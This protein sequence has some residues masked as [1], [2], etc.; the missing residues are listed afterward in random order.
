MDG[1]AG[2]GKSSVGMLAAKEL[3]YD[4]LSTGEMYRALGY[5]T[6]EKKI[7]VDD[8]QKVTEIAKN[9]KFTFERGTDA[10]LKM[11][12]DGEYLGNKLHSEKVGE[13]A[14]KTSAIPSARAVLT[15]KMREIGRGGG[16]IMEGR[17]IGTVVFPDA[18]IKFYIDATPEE[19]AK[20]RFNQLIQR[21]EKAD[22][23]TILECIRAR[24]L[25]D[26]TRTVAPLKPAED[27]FIIDT[28]SMALEQVVEHILS[29]IKE[30]IKNN[31]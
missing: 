29:V 16:I 11:F 4:F 7:A 27:A 3:G 12:V 20:R 30:K 18:E 22:Y 23:E 1:T 5:K 25:R 31:F 6:I 19:R 2:T 10:S 28:S 9:I 8:V 14:S 26:S 21:G 15:D 13:A 24:D 17:D